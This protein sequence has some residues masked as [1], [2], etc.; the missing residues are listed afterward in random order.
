M[1]SATKGYCSQTRCDGLLGRNG[2]SEVVLNSGEVVVRFSHAAL[3]RVESL[4]ESS[5]KD[6]GTA[7]LR[8]ESRYCGAQS[9]RSPLNPYPQSPPPWVLRRPPDPFP[10]LSTF[11]AGAALL[12][13]TS[14]I[15]YLQHGRIVLCPTISTR[16]R[17]AQ[18]AGRWPK[19]ALRN[20]ALAA[21]QPVV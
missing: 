12:S 14:L 2:S 6:E 3:A 13:K 20:A 1:E 9:S 7:E 19:T 5:I 15:T 17:S 18:P 4:L 16:P 11:A 10:Q 21:Q 8:P